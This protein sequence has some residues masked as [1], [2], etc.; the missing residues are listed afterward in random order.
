MATFGYDKINQKMFADQFEADSTGYIYRKSQ[1]GAG[2]HVS[3]AERDTFVA[4]FVRDQRRRNLLVAVGTV[5]LILAILV[6]TTTIYS[7][8]IEP[9]IF[10]GITAILVFAVL[11]WKRS[12]DAPAQTLAGRPTVAG[13]RTKG[14]VAALC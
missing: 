3:L 10:G 12:W 5:V 1:R 9:L 2:I 14:E 7:G 8:P 13:A 11:A 4:D 6:I